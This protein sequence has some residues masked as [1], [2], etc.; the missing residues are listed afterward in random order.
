M[1]ERAM[2]AWAALDDALKAPE[3]NGRQDRLAAAAAAVWAVDAP[4]GREALGA[5]GFDPAQPTEWL[6]QKHAVEL[7]LRAADRAQGHVELLVPRATCPVHQVPANMLCPVDAQLVCALCVVPGAR[8]A[9]HGAHELCHAPL[10]GGAVNDGAGPR[11][12]DPQHGAPRRG[13]DPAVGPRAGG[14]GPGEGQGREHQGGHRARQDA[15]QA[16]QQDAQGAVEVPVGE[17]AP[18]PQAAREQEPQGPPLLAYPCR[19]IKVGEEFEWLPSQLGPR[20]HQFALAGRPEGVQLDE[21]TGLLSGCPKE[22]G[23]RQFTV[24]CGAATC[25]V[26]FAVTP[27][28]PWVRTFAGNGEEGQALSN[29]PLQTNT[30]APQGVAADEHHVYVAQGNGDRSVL[31]FRRRIGAPPIRRG[32]YSPPGGRGS[33]PRGLALDRGS[34]YVTSDNSYQPSL[35][36]VELRPG[37]GTH[38]VANS[39]DYATG[40][41]VHEG[42]RYVACPHDNVV[43]A[44]DPNG[45]IYTVAGN[46]SPGFSGDGGPASDAQLNCP[47]D[48]CVSE[49]ALYIADCGNHCVR[50]VDLGTEY[51]YVTT[52]AGWGETGKGGKGAGKGG[53]KGGANAT[54]AH[55]DPTAIKLQHPRGLCAGDGGE[56]YITDEHRLLVLRNGVLTRVCGTVSSGAADRCSAAEGQ[57]NYPR[58]IAFAAGALYIADCANHRVREISPLKPPQPPA[59]GPQE[60][61]WSGVQGE[62]W[63]AMESPALR[64][65]WGSA[66]CRL[67]LKQPPAGACVAISFAADPQGAELLLG[68]V[69]ANGRGAVALCNGQTRKAALGGDCKRPYFGKENIIEVSIRRAKDN[70]G[71]VIYTLSQFMFSSSEGFSISLSDKSL[72]VTLGPD[73]PARLRVAV[74]PPDGVME[75]L[76]TRPPLLIE[77]GAEE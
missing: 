40:V 53:G 51:R 5:A 57:L 71:G 16:A 29:D 10:A 25:A 55:I 44:V 49:G 24:T 33:G 19:P 8:H 58:G 6:P 34:L 67:A 1:G 65:P 38:T 17:P 3:D 48:V 76:F 23:E 59:G 66:V 35:S 75:A 60:Q 4:G 68:A 2:R 20:G 13:P 15:P 27:V 70:D 9:A 39:M 45:D 42:T 21:E 56:V 28:E 47:E 61:Q 46:G 50:R 41:A 62:Q 74:H 43:R 52:V 64:L 69:E 32:I 63:T 26:S 30:S 54:D 31:C 11:H 37:G 7:V 77:G 18:E 12:A 22:A 14:A 72:C 73:L 36:R